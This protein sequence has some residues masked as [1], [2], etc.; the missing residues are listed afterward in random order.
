M[1]PAS[2]TDFVVCPDCG[3]E[4]QSRV[5]HCI[6]CGAPTR[7]ARETDLHRKENPTFSLPRES[8]AFVLLQ[9]NHLER[10]E[11]LGIFL[12]EHGIPCRIEASEIVPS[13]V[14]RFSY[15]VCVA[16]GDLDRALALRHEHL[17][18][19]NPDLAAEFSALPTIDQCPACGA[20]VSPASA[21]CQSCGLVLLDERSQHEQSRT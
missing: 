19:E 16:E 7:P 17:L 9:D 14:K 13:K 21:E 11:S 8:E 3:S 4:F 18:I 2:D 5:T 1:E 20:R 6:D 10:A 12:E 15:F